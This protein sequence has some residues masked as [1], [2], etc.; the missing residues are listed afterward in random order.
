M[1]RVP[2]DTR[3]SPRSKERTIKIR[4]SPRLKEKQ[5]ATIDS[6]SKKQTI[7]RKG[8]D[9]KRRPLAS[10]LVEGEMHYFEEFDTE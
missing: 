9:K 1:A 6:P 8:V 3:I 4:T 5:V 2:I 7:K 10:S